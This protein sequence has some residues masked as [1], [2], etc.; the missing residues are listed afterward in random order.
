MRRNVTLSI[1]RELILKSRELA[2]RKDMSI[3]KMMDDLLETMVQNEDHYEAAK[4]S[5]LQHLRKK[6]RLGGQITAS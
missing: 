6:M 1:K 4:R 3:S 2:A 5:A